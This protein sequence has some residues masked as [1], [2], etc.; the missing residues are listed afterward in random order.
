MTIRLSV[1][2]TLTDKLVKLL[3]IQ[4]GPTLRRLNC[5]RLALS[6]AAVTAVLH[7]LPVLEQLSVELPWDDLVRSSLGYSY[8]YVMLSF[9]IL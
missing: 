3:I 2:R 1:H 9:R 4:H 8:S 7:G 6:A 5:F